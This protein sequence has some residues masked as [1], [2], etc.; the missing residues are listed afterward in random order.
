MAEPPA[1][2]TGLRKRAVAMTM[3]EK[4]QNDRRRL[5]N[6]ITLASQAA[7]PSLAKFV[8]QAAP[9]IH[10][11]AGVVNVLGPVY[12]AL[13]RAL[14]AVYSVLPVDLLYA[15]MGLA[16]CFFGGTYCASIAAVEAFT[17]LGWS[18][19]RAALEDIYDDLVSIKDANDADEKKDD[20]GDGVADVLALP[21]AQ[22]MQRKMR[23]AALAI[24]D[25]EKLSTAI[26]GLYAGWVAVQGTLRLQFAKTIT[27]GVSIA[28]M[29]DAPA[30]R[31]GVPFLTTFVPRELH[32]WIP[33]MIRTASKVVAVAFAWYVQVI[34][35]AFQS[36]LRG[37]LICSRAVL[38]WANARGL[39]DVEEDDTYLDEVAGYTLA[40]L[41]FYT[42]VRRAARAGAARPA[43]APHQPPA[44]PPSACAV[45]VGLRAA[46]PVQH[47]HVPVHRRRVLH[48]LLG[49]QR[50]ARRV[51]RS[52]ACRT[53]E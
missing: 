51:S 32:K 1:T 6:M 53:S 3:S 42:Q 2:P 13:F 36:A 46:L 45:G 23:V 9:A 29:L 37:G 8:Q 44:P 7:P 30:L 49:H 40:A 12:F 25:P 11:V 48:P 10:V 17:L 22:L 31:Y 33:T 14:A 41:G 28:R 24:K 27:L 4:K 34:I 15:L 43:R 26:G 39:I 50:R 16:M 20:D 35:S 21:P 38:R 5:D 47:R 19:T 52:R 18:T